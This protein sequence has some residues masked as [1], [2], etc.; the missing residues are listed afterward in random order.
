MYPATCRGDPN[1]CHDHAGR[2][3]ECRALEKAARMTLIT[4][5]GGGPPA[6]PANGTPCWLEI[7]SID[8][9]STM[10]FYRTVLGWDYEHRLDSNRTDYVIALLDGEPVAGI[11][12]TRQPVRDWTVYLAASDASALA[13]RAARY[14]ATLIES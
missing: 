6:G 11:R 14:G 3:P 2:A 12:P 4:A 5:Q 8:V 1:L 13:G 10:R 7:A 9:D